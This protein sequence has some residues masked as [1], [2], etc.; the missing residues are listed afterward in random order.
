MGGS[1]DDLSATDDDLRARAIHVGQKWYRRDG[2]GS[3]TIV[4]PNLHTDDE[5]FVHTG[6]VMM[7]LTTKQIRRYYSV[8]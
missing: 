6:A 5:W 2:E 3:I 4:G 8:R 7:M 1:R